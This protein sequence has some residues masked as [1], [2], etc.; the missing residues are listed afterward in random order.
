MFRELGEW[1]S[2]QFAKLSL[3]NRRKGS[4]PLL[5]ASVSC[6]CG[7]MVYTTD[8]KSV[9]RKGLRVQVPPLVPNLSR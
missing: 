8:L 5:S 2:Q 4:N 7:G 9:A 6:E 1:L 3:R